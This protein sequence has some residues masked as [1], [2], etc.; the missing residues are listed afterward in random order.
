MRLEVLLFSKSLNGLRGYISKS[1]ELT[2][3]SKI[4]LL[5]NDINVPNNYEITRTMGLIVNIGSIISSI[6]MF[7][8]L[9]YNICFF[10]NICLSIGFFVFIFILTNIVYYL[11]CK[12]R[13]PILGAKKYYTLKEKRAPC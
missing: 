5:P 9:K 10:S 3:N 1:I 4:T 6:Y 13:I 8:Y 12:K 2:L 7:V 11:I